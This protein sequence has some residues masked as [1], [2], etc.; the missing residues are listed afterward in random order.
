MPTFSHPEYDL[1]KDANGDGEKRC[2]KCKGRGV[3]YIPK[4]SPPVSIR[5]EC[6]IKKDSAYNMENAWKG[7]SKAPGVKSSKLL[8]YTR[9][10][11]WVTSSVPDFRN[12]LKT[13]ADGMGHKWVFKVTSDSELVNIWLSKLGDDVMDPDFQLEG[14]TEG[15]T[16]NRFV[17][18]PSLLI[19]QLGVKVAS[20]RETPSVVQEAISIRYHQDKPTWITDQP[21]AKLMEGHK[22]YSRNLIDTL[23]IFDFKR[24]HVGD[25][26]APTT[27][28]GFTEA[29]VGYHVEHPQSPPP[30]PMRKVKSAFG[31]D[32]PSSQFRKKKF[33][34]FR[35]D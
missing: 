32:E 33:K 11:L 10:N 28:N 21:Y 35:E 25:Q 20:N 34:S 8:E 12:H 29:P 26:E 9:E 6:T 31:E 24:L 1:T 5:C 17:S 30:G 16:L 13:V 3:T 22:A 18:F 7:L 4:S 27:S 15:M 2:E 23:Q 19:I 14:I